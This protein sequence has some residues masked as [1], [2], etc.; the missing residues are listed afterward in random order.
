M[1]KLILLM[2][3]LPL[4]TAAGAKAEVV[5][6]AAITARITAT[7]TDLIFFCIALY[8]YVCIYINCNEDQLECNPSSVC[9]GWLGEIDAL[10]G[11]R[12]CSLTPRA[13]HLCQHHHGR[14]MSW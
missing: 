14:S 8:L 9:T 2:L 3:L 10:V 7:N 11:M 13:E 1:W 6:D 12:S 5:D 4:H